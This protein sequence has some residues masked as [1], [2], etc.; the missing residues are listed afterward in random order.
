[1]K[2]KENEEEFLTKGNNPV[3]NSNS[4]PKNKGNILNLKKRNKNENVKQKK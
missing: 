2:M 4:E 3:R 1:M